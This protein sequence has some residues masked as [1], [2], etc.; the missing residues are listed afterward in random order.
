PVPP[1]PVGGAFVEPSPGISA[2]VPASGMPLG[3]PAAP[4]EPWVSRADGTFRA[5]PAS[6]GRVQVIA[7][8]PQYM[9]ALSA[10]VTLVPTGEAEVQVVMR[11]G[12]TLEGRVVDATDRPVEGARVSL[13][14]TR[15]GFERSTRTARDGTFAF[16]SVPEEV[17]VAAGDNEDAQPDVRM[18]VRV[19]E[20]GRREVTVRLPEARP[21]LPV[22]VVDD[23][24]WPIPRARVSA[25]SLAPDVPLRTTGFADAQGELLLRRAAGLALRVEASAPG[26][27]PGVLQ[28]DGTT[29]LRI[30]LAPAEGASGEVVAAAGFD[31]VRGA[32]VA[33]TT[34]L[35]T[36]RTR[37]DERG[38]YALDDLPSGAATLRA[39]ALGFAPAAAV[40]TIPDSG[41]RRRV[42]L[43]RLELRAEGIAEGE[44][45]DGRGNPVAGARVA[46][47]HAPTWLASGAA[48]EAGAI[49][50]A[51][52]RF[53][54]H[55]LPEGVLVLEAYAP[56]VGRGRA[57]GVAVVAG[58]TTSGVRI[59]LA[60][61]RDDDGR[62]GGAGPAGGV[63]ITLG[64]AGGEVVVVSVAPESEAERAGLAAGDVI[65]SVDGAA[66]GT[67]RETRERLGGSLSDDVVLRVRRSDG[68]R[69]LRVRR[70]A[71]HH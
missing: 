62:A 64:E 11:R 51:R 5:F 49:T 69:T 33:L 37:T 68:E 24:G 55:E 30:A 36:R 41:G 46:E 38:A 21:A 56:E 15:G 18:S 52:G 31:P 53:S 35:G 16:A 25:I 22:T 61:A 59:V 26:Y 63:A 43:P 67:M 2:F 3:A 14:A 45:V 70:E 8:H 27:A 32:E 9:E 42:V 44:V 39:R 71:V 60:R 28:T 1:P 7:R 4:A 20:G 23:R 66:A 6:P 17:S 40:V 10:V 57:G 34:E 65:V 47:G 13:A 19:P 29:E 12:G 48:P 54:V 50:D 58:R